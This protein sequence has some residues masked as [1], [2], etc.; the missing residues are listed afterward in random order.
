MSESKVHLVA[1]LT[2]A[3]LI[4]QQV[5]SNAVRDGLFLS[6]FAVTTL[7][8]FIAG[9]ALLAIPAAQR[10]GR[11]LV[12]FGP[13]RVVPALLALGAVLFLTEW[14]LLG[15]RPGAA[16]I[17]LYLHSSVL[18][19]VAISAFWSLLNERF[20][21]HSAKPLLARV[22]A[23]ATLGGLVGGIGAERV[24]ALL[25]QR[26]LFVVLAG[27]AA[28]ALTGALLIASGAPRRPVPAETE[29]GPGGWSEIRRLPF[30]RNLALLV[31]LAALLAALVDYVLKAEAV[32][33][34]G[35][36]EP[37]VRFFGLFYAGTGFAAFLIQAAL[38]RFALTRLGLD[39]SVASHPAVVGAAALLG[40][41]LPAPW[42]GILPRALDLSVRNSVFRAGYELFYTPLAE[43]TKRSAKSIVDV[44]WDCFGKATGAGLV[45]VLTR[46]GPGYALAAVNGAA[47][48]AAGAEI[49][50]ARRLRAGYVGAL[51]GGLRRQAD[52][53]TPSPQYTLA[54]FTAVQSL[55]GLDRSAILAALGEA[56]ERKGAGARHS[57]PVVTAVADLRSGDPARIRAALGPPLRD[58]L[59]IGA[60]IPLL[61]RSDVLRPAVDAL[62][63]CGPRAAGQLV[64][65]ML[66]P[67]TPEVVR[68]RIPLVLKSCASPLAREGLVQA[69]AAPSRELRIRSGRALL[70]LTGDHPELAVPTA[71]AL[72]AVERELAAGDA[73]DA[74]EHVFNLLALALERE[75]MHIA[76][77]AFA[78][79]DPYLRGTALEYLET[80]LAPSLFAAL[81]PHLSGAG[82]AAPRRRPTAEARADLL[83]AGATMRV[84]LEDVRRQ[85]ASGD[86]GD[87]D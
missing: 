48:I 6:H 55:G 19:G 30:L 26:A 59:L 15:P 45:V 43:A 80:V 63:A 85:L 40:F 77:R 7:P 73:G 53:A 50:V 12:R 39:G 61:A 83:R 75:P 78:T 29:E 27:I 67:G 4:A 60:V 9:A 42:R 25:S 68:R 37:L 46:L 10:S 66:D 3:A 56:G 18:G 28:V 21:P 54:D 82:A 16:A 31:A 76:A 62:V 70:V 34:Y 58:P 44:A 81:K 24:A 79:D 86:P 1:P 14:A 65:A 41:F 84:S 32:A 57:D 52:E 22:A 11:L 17:V 74:R 47:V 36:G 8:Y 71:E 87:G 23:A 5:G 35:K 72:A 69:L 64:D 49:A 13:T 33:H 20:D 51:E 2:A 38:G